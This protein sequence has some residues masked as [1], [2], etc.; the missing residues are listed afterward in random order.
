M[1]K[2]RHMRT[3]RKS[4]CTCIRGGSLVAIVMASLLVAPA[5]DAN[6]HDESTIVEE[7]P[8]RC[9]YHTEGRHAYYRNCDAFID[10]WIEWSIHA[11]EGNVHR[12][13]WVPGNATI[14]LGPA[15]AVEFLISVGISRKFLPS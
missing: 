2:R 13:S 7:S 9:G 5:S 3:T 11:E 15:D 8:E 6:E 1:R 12:A 4:L 10:H 14:P